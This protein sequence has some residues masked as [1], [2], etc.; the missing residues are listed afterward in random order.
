VIGRKVWLG[1]NTTVVTGVTIN[2][3]AIV[4]AGAVVTKHVPRPGAQRGRPAEHHRRRRTRQALRT[5]G[6]DAT[7]S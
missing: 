4:G 3:G 6:F 5:S 7:I 1:A 2:G